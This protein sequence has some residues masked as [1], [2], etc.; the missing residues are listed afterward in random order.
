MEA[1]Q[2]LYNYS[3]ANK[4]DDGRL[5]RIKTVDMVSEDLSNGLT[6]KEAI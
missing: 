3:Q 2:I 1:I 4:T 6:Y 5:Q